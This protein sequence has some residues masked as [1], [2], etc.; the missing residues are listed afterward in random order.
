VLV[1]GIT[2]S[3]KSTTLA[4]MVDYINSQRACHIVTIEDP[5]EYAFKD[6]RS[7]INQREVGFDT[8]SFSKALRAALRQDP[9]VVLVG[10]MRDLETTEI[11]MTAA[12]TGHLVLSTLHTVDA[13]ETVN[14]IVSLYPPHQQAQAR[15]QIV[16]VLKGII[17]Q[18]L[19]PR[20][21]G[22]GMIPAAEILVST[23]RV[24]ELIAD[25]Q[26]T[27]EI[28]DAIETGRDPYGMISFDQSLTELVQRKLVTYDEAVKASSNPD[29]FALY[30]RGFTKGGAG[31][32]DIPGQSTG[33]P[34]AQ[35]TRNAY[36]T[37]ISNPT[38]QLGGV[39]QTRIQQA[40]ATRVGEAAP[41]GAP[42]FQIDRFTKG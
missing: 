38:A 13:V 29:D 4:A 32:M 20:A 34:T 24:R 9:D 10:E 35:P 26:R 5:V 3:G 40:T 17:S 39:S 11:A 37:Q 12:E 25:A 21:D 31:G 41:P 30:F 42:D 23:A 33:V 1:T 18:R 22:R 6:R 28:H 36:A 14:R 7:V 15:L 19:V 16:T 2:G 27:R 8:T